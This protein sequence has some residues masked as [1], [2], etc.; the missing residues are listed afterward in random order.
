MNQAHLPLIWGPPRQA[1]CYQETN[2]FRCNFIIC[3]IKER[4]PS[5]FWAIFMTFTFQTIHWRSSLKRIYSSQF[6]FS[7]K[8]TIVLLITFRKRNISFV[9]NLNRLSWMAGGFR[10]QL[11][12]GSLVPS[13]V[14]SDLVVDIKEIQISESR[15][16]YSIEGAP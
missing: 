16:V 4:I 3:Q 10:D 6:D 1:W 2:S 5:L 11:K 14:F 13:L 9:K 7:L 12:L 8:K 15:L